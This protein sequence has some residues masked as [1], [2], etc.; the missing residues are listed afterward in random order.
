MKNLFV[1][2][3]AL[4]AVW[5]GGAWAAEDPNLDQQLEELST[6]T[7]ELPPT[8]TKEKLYSVQS[9]YVPLRHRHEFTLGGGKNFNTDS[10]IT[11]NNLDLGYR[12]YLTDR[13]YLNLNGSYVFNDWSNGANRLISEGAAT[14][15]T[16]ADVAFA[17]Y[18]ADLLVGYNLFYGKFRVSMDQV[19]YFDQYVALGPGYVDMVLGN[20]AAAVAELGIV[21][22][23]GKSASL[24]FGL[25]D[26]FVKEI[27]TKSTG[28][29]HNMIGGLQVGYVFGG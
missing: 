23:F 18:R 3:M 1:V 21:F 11:S 17:R 9:R 28:W 4:S 19:F 25:K 13:W 5:A 6:P 29:A 22:W 27:R 24:R 20:Q 8:V 10:F 16:L 15:S 2:I 14:N 26:Y 12:F 7:N